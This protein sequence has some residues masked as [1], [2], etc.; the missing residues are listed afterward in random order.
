MS[1]ELVLV[2]QTRYRHTIPSKHQ[3]SLDTRL[4]WLWNQRFGTVQTIWQNT[5]DVLDKTACTL[6][7]QAIM[8]QDLQSIALLFHRI[9]GGALNDEDLVGPETMRL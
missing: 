1:T 4:H 2:K 7:L 5:D 6:I 3:Q 9:E 8:A